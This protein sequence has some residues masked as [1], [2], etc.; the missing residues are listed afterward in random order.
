M[1]Y[2][3]SRPSF[4]RRGGRNRHQLDPLVE[5]AEKLRSLI[6]MVGDKPI[7]AVAMINDVATV[8]VRDYHR[9][10]DTVL[11]TFAGCTAELSHKP[12]VYACM[13][14][15]ITAQDPAVGKTILESIHEHLHSAFAHDRASQLRSMYRFFA[16]AT[17]LHLFAA[18]DYLAFLITPLLASLAN[19]HTDNR[20]DLYA[21][22]LLA[23]IP[24][25]PVALRAQ[26]PSILAAIEQY[27]TTRNASAERLAALEAL[28]PLDPAVAPFEQPDALSLT[29]RQVSGAFQAAAAAAGEAD[30]DAVAGSVFPM[31]TWPQAFV[32]P[33]G[34]AAP[35][36]LAALQLP[37]HVSIPHFD[38]PAPVMFRVFDDDLTVVPGT[39]NEFVPQVPKTLTMERMVAVDVLHDLLNNIQFN[40]KEGVRYLMDL[41]LMFQ[42]G[43]FVL[44]TEEAAIVGPSQGK[45]P[46]APQ[47]NFEQLLMET[48]FGALF[49]LPLP[50][51][52]PVFYTDVVMGLAR[53]SPK[54]IAPALGKAIQV[55]FGRLEAMDVDCLVRLV[56][57][58]SHHLSNFSFGWNWNDWA[59]VLGGIDENDDAMDTDEY[60]KR[61]AFVLAVL[62][63]ITRLAYHDRIKGTLPAAFH[64]TYDRMQPT[65]VPEYPSPQHASF[66][67]QIADQ[68]RARA[69]ADDV[70]AY[71]EQFQRNMGEDASP[72]ALRHTVMTA[73]LAHGQKTFSH[74]M[75]V[76]ERYLAVLKRLVA[77]DVAAKRHLVA[78]TYA[79][80]RHNHQ[81]FLIVLDKLLHYRV[82]EPVHAAQWLVAMVQGEQEALEPMGSDALLAEP[83]DAPGPV[84]VLEVL[85]LTIKK[86]LA[87]IDLLEDKL[88]RARAMDSENEGDITTIEANLATA[89]PEKHTLFVYI[90]ESLLDQAAQEPQSHERT[91]WSSWTLGSLL[92][93]LRMYFADLDGDLRTEIQNLVMQ[94]APSDEMKAVFLA[95]LRME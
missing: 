6:I 49:R 74:T 65:S 11:T 92:T 8:I 73:L 78:S 31:T 30:G 2:H 39:E 40:H 61:R 36:A 45:H 14:A 68:V 72:V 71:T 90:T 87:R 86:A 95:V 35:L 33:A 77:G 3:G 82:L 56:D 84:F 42:E 12:H 5:E 25:V 9:H 19:G 60:T 46:Q 63:R 22:I 28:R 15:A 79:F 75:T 70:W 20:N 52:R 32:Q 81:F 54:R 91:Q 76:L 66:A 85:C 41:K 24:F 53:S 38:A 47:Y 44:D 34:E 37:E 55:S 21:S 4:P 50:Q 83:L 16:C 18:D 62:D 27:V 67:E 57:L 48:L 23:A 94:R 10:Q 7:Q 89:I 17:E 88:R 51:V 43:T 29:L 69:P 80:W 13:L 58:F 64:A 93:L 59:F 1:S 26:V